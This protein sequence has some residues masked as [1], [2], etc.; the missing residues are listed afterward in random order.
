MKIILY[1]KNEKMCTE[2]KKKFTC[3][4]D[5]EVKHCDFKELECKY[6]VTAGNSYGWMTGGIDLVVRDYYGQKIQDKIQEVIL[7]KVGRYLQVGE[8]I[9]IYTGDKKKPNLIYAP[10]ME[11]PKRISKID[12]FYVFEKLLEKYNNVNFACC[13][14]GAGT[15][16]ISEECA[17]QMMLAYKYY[18]ESE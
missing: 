9:V 16:G 1:D 17:K 15:G 12:V 2:W 4:N 6:V 8:S 3:F 11:M 14:L 18:K 7:G 10:T 5:V 13:G